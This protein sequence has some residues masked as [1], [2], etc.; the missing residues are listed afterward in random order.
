MCVFENSY[1]LFCALFSVAEI[2]GGGINF[3]KH[4]RDGESLA[5]EELC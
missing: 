5:Y 2:D 1:Q 4:Q 3:S